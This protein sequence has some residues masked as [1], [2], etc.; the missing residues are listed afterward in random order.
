MPGYLPHHL[1]PP[2]QQVNR[3]TR[4]PRPDVVVDTTGKHE[5]TENADGGIEIHDAPLPWAA[6]ALC[7][8]GVLALGLMLGA[9]VVIVF[10]V[11]AS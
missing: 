5:F 9:A 6:L 2:G 1:H 10:A 7:A 8:V 4:K 11:V 3:F